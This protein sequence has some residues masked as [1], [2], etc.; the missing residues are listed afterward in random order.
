VP[1]AKRIAERER[2]EREN[3]EK[4]AA[5][6]EEDEEEDEE[7]I[8]SRR[9]RQDA[10]EKA[11][12]LENATDMFRGVSIQDQ[13]L[14]K[15]IASANPRS[16]EEFEEFRKVLMERIETFKTQRAY[17]AFIESL[18]TE[19]SRSLKDVEVRKIA[20]ALTRIANEKQ[21]E[22]KE[23]HKKKTSKRPAVQVSNVLDTTN[24][25]DYGDYDDFM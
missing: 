1:L 4:R 24:Y 21:R 16:K 5:A 3:A 10:L 20:S 17:P 18:T 14:A 9:R 11:A 8:V 15:K 23:K 19:L 25:D 7:D 2:Q 22:A 13:E 6:V 12:D